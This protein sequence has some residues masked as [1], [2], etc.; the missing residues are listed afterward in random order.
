M[1]SKKWIHNFLEEESFQD[2]LFQNSDQ[3]ILKKEKAL[4][5]NAA[6]YAK[7]SNKIN[8]QADWK[9]L[10]K[11]LKTGRLISLKSLLKY[12]AILGIPL[13][14]GARF[15][16][17][18]KETSVVQ[19]TEKKQQKN[20]V[21]LILQDGSTVDL[22]AAKQA[23]GLNGLQ[24]FNQN[25]TLDYTN[26]KTATADEPVF[27]TLVVPRGS[28]YKLVLEDSTQIWINADTRI[29]YQVNI[30]KT[31]TREVYLESGEAYFK[32]SKNPKKPFVVHNGKMNV[33]V[34]GTSF[35]MNTYADNIQ[36]TL[37]EGKVKVSTET[38][39]HL[40]L[41]P[42]QQSNFNRLNG[43]LEK[44]EVD[45]YP[46]VSWKDGVITFENETMDDL[47]ETIGRL[48]D[49]DIQIKDEDIKKWHFSGSADKKE[50]IKDV[51]T[52]IQKTSQLKFTI[53][54]RS[55]I[56]EKAD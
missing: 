30:N 1:N 42:G 50:S 10:Q 23:K 17:F 21:M 38:S 34:L 54:E 41:T 40:E 33:Q 25:S 32:V 16:I 44:Q 12:A 7:Y 20:K 43:S 22:Q 28:D 52:I 26:A 4:I 47:M 24:I 5:E 14:I 37:V 39:K 49:Y 3:E 18:N 27:N 11:R 6:L 15:Y 56:V 55:I 13:M 46:F 51:L 36:T 35:N 8:S 48:Y 29:K 31:A 2:Q 53:K 45:V 9:Q 19:L